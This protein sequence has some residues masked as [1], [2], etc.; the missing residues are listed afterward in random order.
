MKNYWFDAKFVYVRGGPK[1]PDRFKNI[2]IVL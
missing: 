1:D 2:T